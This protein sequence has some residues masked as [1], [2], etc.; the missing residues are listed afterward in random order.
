MDS[1]ESLLMV[2][3]EKGNQKELEQKGSVR[4]S[5]KSATVLQAASQ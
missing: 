3:E 2:S 4:I 5:H 1:F